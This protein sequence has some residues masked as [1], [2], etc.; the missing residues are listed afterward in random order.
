MKKK[1]KKENINNIEQIPRK[2]LVSSVRNTNWFDIRYWNAP[3]KKK[4]IF[5]LRFTRVGDSKILL[6]NLQTMKFLNHE[7]HFYIWVKFTYHVQ[8]NVS[9]TFLW[10]NCD[11]LWLIINIALI[12]VSTNCLVKCNPQEIL[13]SIK[14]IS[15]YCKHPCW[16][17]K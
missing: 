7:V 13:L 6:I 8:K 10:I 11:I 17:A 12:L 1:K 2:K 5:Q 9:N 14:Q 3:D 15:I 4:K 16:E